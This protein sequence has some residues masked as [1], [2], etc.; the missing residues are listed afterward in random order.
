[1]GSEHV[2]TPDHPQWPIFHSR[3]SRVFACHGTTENARAIL[4]AM[5]GIDVQTSL[6]ALWALGG[7]CDCAIDLDIAPLPER[8]E[9]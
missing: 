8:L 1:M 7:T 2:M 6:D 3:L 4:A 9:A 5:P